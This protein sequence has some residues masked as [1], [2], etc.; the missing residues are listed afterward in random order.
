LNTTQIKKNKTKTVF[1]KGM[2]FSFDAMISF[3]ILLFFIF[4]LVNFISE[5]YL[6]E[7]QEVDHFFL[8]EKVLLCADSFVKNHNPQNT[9]LGAAIVD[10]EKKRAESNKLTLANILQAKPYSTGNFFIKK[11]QYYNQNQET[12]TIE[13]STVKSQN[14]ISSKRF[15]LID[16]EKSIIEFT[17]CIIDE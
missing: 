13:L 3:L 16:G 10:T 4:V 9:T 6:F 12:Q 11:I 2:I 5:K 1:S 17:G 7:K 15:V 14:C 8:E